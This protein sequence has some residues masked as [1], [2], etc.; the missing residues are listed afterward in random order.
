MQYQGLVRHFVASCHVKR[1]VYKSEE[2]LAPHPTTKLEDHS[3]SSGC[4]CLFTI[5]AAVL[6]I[7]RPFPPSAE[8]I[9]LIWISDTK[10]WFS[11]ACQTVQQRL[12]HGQAQNSSHNKCSLS[13]TDSQAW[14]VFTEV[15]HDLSQS[16]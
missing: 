4:D 8:D 13:V 11:P 12:L 14:S 6:H 3:T 1:N 10:N 16:L 9:C 2:L 15:F 7:W 5:I